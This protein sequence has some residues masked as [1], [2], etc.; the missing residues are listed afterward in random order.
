[1]PCYPL[2]VI[3]TTNAANG[4]FLLIFQKDVEI[5]GFYSYSR[6]IAHAE[7]SRRVGAY[8]IRDMVFS[9]TGIVNRYETMVMQNSSGGGNYPKPLY[10]S[11]DL[12]GY[13]SKEFYIRVVGSVGTYKFSL[14][15]VF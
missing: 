3:F 4:G 8:S 6:N 14:N 13:K 7:I 11:F 9:V 5:T 1:M 2:T 15:Y 10:Y 12:V